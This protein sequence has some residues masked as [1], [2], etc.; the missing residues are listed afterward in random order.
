MRNDRGLGYLGIAAL[1]LAAVFL[2]LM[3]VD[4]GQQ[5]DDPSIASVV[6]PGVVDR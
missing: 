5:A 3:S 2:L 1:I 4:K 6:A